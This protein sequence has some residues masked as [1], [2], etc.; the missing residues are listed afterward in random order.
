MFARLPYDGG[1]EAVAARGRAEAQPSIPAGRG[2]PRCRPKD[3]AAES[4][5][6]QPLAPVID[7]SSFA[8]APRK[9]RIEI[10]P[11]I[12]VIFFLLATSV[13]FTLSLD[14]IRA[15]EVPMPMPGPPGEAN[16]TLFLQASAHGTYYWKIGLAGAPE[17]ISTAELRPRLDEYQ[18]SVPAPRVFIRGDDKATLGD[19]VLAL[20]E[21]RKVGIKQVSVETIPSRSGN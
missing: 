5:S 12:D 13:L 9:A 4:L 21:V 18:R 17:A 6:F 7:V 19:A 20:D 11:L 8:P 1:A 2:F 14:K 16:D 3:R 15:L 10:I